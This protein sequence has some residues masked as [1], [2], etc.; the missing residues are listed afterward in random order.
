[1]VSKA[2]KKHTEHLH[3]LQKL[4]KLPFSASVHCFEISLKTTTNHT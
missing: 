3:K 2:K 4:E 1:M